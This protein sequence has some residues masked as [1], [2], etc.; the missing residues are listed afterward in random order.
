[1]FRKYKN[2]EEVVN[3][4]LGNVILKGA[5]AGK[6]KILTAAEFAAYQPAE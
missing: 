6:Y 5:E 2:G 1:M 3:V 4:P